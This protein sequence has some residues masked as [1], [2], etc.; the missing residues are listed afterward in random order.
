MGGLSLWVAAELRRRWTSLVVLAVLVAIA[1][2]VATALVAGAHRADTALA[3]FRAATGPYNLIA[4]MSLGAEKPASAE[5]LAGR[6]D[7]QAAAV[8]ELSVVPGVES[9][10]VESWWGI[11]TLPDFDAPSTVSAFAVGI[12]AAH[13]QRY[14][15]V[16]IEGAWP[17]DDDP[18]A[19]V[20]NEVAARM[21]GW[22]VGSRQRFETVSADR[23]FEWFSNDAQF[24]TTAALDGPPIEV[25]VAAVVRHEADLADD[26]YPGMLFPEGFADAHADEIAHIEPFALIHAD[27]ARLDDVRH[28]VESIVAPIGMKV[29]PAPALGEAAPAVIP[30]V[31]VEV[32]TL[33]IAAVVAAIAGLFVVAQALGRHLATSTIDDPVRSA[34]GMTN[35][36]Q[37]VGKWLGIAPALLAG[38]IGVPCVA[39]LLS[40]TLPRGLARKV[41]P[42]PGVRLETLPVALGT[43]ATAVA[44]LALVAVMARSAARSH[45]TEQATGA[46]KQRALGRPALTLGVSFAVDPAGS[47]RSRAGT[48]AALASIALGMAAVVTVATLDGS[49]TKLLSTPVLYGAPAALA[50]E[51]NGMVGVTAAVE[52]ATTTPG[53]AAVTRRLMIN[54]DTMVANGARRAAV[55]PEAMEPL[56][57]SALPPLRDGR[58]PQTVDDV[59]VGAATAKDLGVRVGDTVGISPLDGSAPLTLRVTGIVVSSGADDAQHAFIVTV[60]T[61][62]TL[63]CAG[64]ELD[65]CN[66]TADVFADVTTDTA[67]EALIDAG[68]RTTAPPA[69]VARLDEVGPLPWYLAGFLCFLAAAGLL[70]QLTITLR[71]RAGDLAVVRALGLPARGAATALSWQA[72]VTLATGIV[73]GAAAGMVSGPL[74]WRTIAASLGVEPVTRLP[75]AA[76][77]IAAGAG[78]GLAVLVSLGPRWR[79]ARL[80]LAATLRA[81]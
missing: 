36:Q 47:G 32:T 49:R 26:G 50:F 39:W 71:R 52:Q 61:L 45:R 12:S 72:V 4:E 6:L 67:R 37:L 68:F 34:L 74:V 41:E 51:S 1:G 24:T 14:V 57:G 66:V 73:I 81:E 21:L 78:A 65:D 48:W 18:D 70:H 9:V 44:T 2:G 27:P 33:R 3:R 54:D 42:D 53:V 7:E 79:A 30:T 75:A 77:P 69:N 22:T 35:R 80:P 13:G 58:H 62:R 17:A 29:S 19:V 38:A 23:M 60:P 25:E 20:V 46:W 55:E 8:T 31:R 10:S 63:L 43:V 16:V 64:H 28:R 15:P 40:G 11:R 76:I 5:E 59:A 56:L